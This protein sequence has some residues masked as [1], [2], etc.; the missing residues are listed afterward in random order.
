MAKPIW[1]DYYVDLGEA[2]SIVYRISYTENNEQKVIFVGKSNMR[3]GA[4]DANQV[5]INDICADYLVTNVPNFKANGVV[6]DTYPSF[7]IETFDEEN[8]V[9]VQADAQTFTPDWSYE[10]YFIEISGMAAPIKPIIDRR[11]ALLYSVFNATTILY[12]QHGE[13]PNPQGISVNGSGTISVMHPSTALYTGITINGQ[14]YKYV[15][16]CAEWVMHYVNAYGGWDSLLIDGN[17]SERDD[18]KRHNISQ[19]Y[20]NADARERGKRNFVNELTKVFTLHTGW[21]SDDESS[22][23]HHLLNSTNVYM[24]NLVDG[25]II[26]VVLT[27]S[28]TEYKTYKTNGRQM[29]DYTIEAEVAREMVRK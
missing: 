25:R 7:K 22:R 26:P 10:D 29:V 28:T 4:E 19:E 24:Q 5:R 23:M 17:V 8:G 27:N 6:H 21:L 16:S 12:E 2:E 13:I 9:W 1:R 11:Q 14:Y 18:L 15:D 3:P 20:Y